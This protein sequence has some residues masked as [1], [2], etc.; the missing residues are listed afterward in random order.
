MCVCVKCQGLSCVLVLLYPLPFSPSSRKVEK[1]W[2]FIPSAT[3][4]VY[5][6]RRPLGYI[7][8]ERKV[9]NIYFHFIMLSK[10]SAVKNIPCVLVPG[11]VISQIR[12]SAGKNIFGWAQKYLRHD[13]TADANTTTINYDP[14]SWRYARYTICFLSAEV[15]RILQLLELRVNLR[16]TFYF[17]RTK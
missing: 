12:G 4:W 13:V 8:S 9:T 1:P 10:L 17:F 7:I 14:R 11:P 5:I 15:V 6:M 2:I 16:Q 3:F